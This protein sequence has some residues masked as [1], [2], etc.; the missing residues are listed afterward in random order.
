MRRRH[1]RACAR[2]LRASQC[3]LTKIIDYFTNHEGRD[4]YHGVTYNHCFF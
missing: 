2:Q 3:S 4:N 1:M